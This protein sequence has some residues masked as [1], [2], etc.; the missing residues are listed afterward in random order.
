[1]AGAAVIVESEVVS[2]RLKRD[3]SAPI[4]KKNS[5]AHVYT[6]TNGGIAQKTL[7]ENSVPSE[8]RNAPT[9]KIIFTKNHLHAILEPTIPSRGNRRLFKIS[10]MFKICLYVQRE[11]ERCLCLEACLEASVP[12]LE[13]V[14]KP[15]AAA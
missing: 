7:T 2:P 10:T 11:E 15:K 9:A 1:M 14:W 13:A 4:A 8:K 5:I 6:S 12:C 3:D